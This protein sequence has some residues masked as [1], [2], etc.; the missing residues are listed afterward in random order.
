VMLSNRAYRILKLNMLDYLGEAASGREFVAM[1]L[2]QPELRFDHMAEAMGVPS[3]RVEDPDQLPGVLEEAI[4]H[5][6]GPFLVDV[7]LE[8]PIPGR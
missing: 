8:S 1:D 4:G 5:R 7:V 2:T 6:G 3:R